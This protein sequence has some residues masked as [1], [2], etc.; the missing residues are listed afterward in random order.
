MLLSE[1]A[2]RSAG[3][4]RYGFAPYAER[5]VGAI[6][7][8]RTLPLVV[9]IHGPWG[10]GKTSFMNLCAEA[11]GD[12]RTHVI[13]FNPWKYDKKEEVWHAFIQTMLGEVAA[14]LQQGKKRRLQLRRYLRDLRRLSGAAAWL[15]AKWSTA[16]A[17]GGLVKESDLEAVRGIWSQSRTVG[18]PYTTLNHFEQ[19]LTDIMHDV[20]ESHRLVVCIDDLD[21]CGPTTIL[22]ILES[23][24]LFFGMAPC[25]FLLAADDDILRNAVADSFKGNVAR[26][27]AYLEKLVHVP[28][29]LPK[30]TMA[31]IYAAL[32]D[33]IAFRDADR[34]LWELIR[35]SYGTNTRK[36]QRFISAYN[37]LSL[38]LQVHGADVAPP[39]RD[40]MLKVATLL[41]LRL[42]HPQFY[43]EVLQNSER[44]RNVDASLGGRSTDVDVRELGIDEKLA[45][46]LRAVSSRRAGYNFPPV[47]NDLEIDALT[48]VI[49]VAATRGAQIGDGAE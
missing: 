40:R 28:F 34:E 30:V 35:C 42:Q 6:K 46:L 16:L 31:S 45:R 37:I 25:V 5:L 2:I 29:Q 4:D 32:S 36:V 41:T 13:R 38:V 18:E 44:W 8:V 39:S 3:E 22:D 11:L 15:T 20:G 17:T 9:G 14:C 12:G 43:A 19:V 48:S 47:P 26:A 24:K 33:R 7:E 49:G 27:D 1:G 21:R 10:S 23:L